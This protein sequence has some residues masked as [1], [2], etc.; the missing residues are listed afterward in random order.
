MSDLET[1]LNQIISIKDEIHSSGDSLTAEIRDVERSLSGR[2]GAVEVA[3]ATNGT[4]TKTHAREIGELRSAL[5]LKPSRRSDAPPK[6]R[7]FLSLA[8]YVAIGGIGIGT[9]IGAVFAAINA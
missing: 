3:V 5:K 9:A 2:L 8:K 4:E 7:D 1:V 6:K